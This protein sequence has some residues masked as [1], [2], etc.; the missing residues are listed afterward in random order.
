MPAEHPVEEDYPY[1]FGAGLWLNLK[2]LAFGTMNEGDTKT[3]K[4]KYANDTEH[5]MKLTFVVIGG[6]TDIKFTSPRMV[7]AKGRGEMVVTY[8]CSGN[9]LEM[10]KAHI[11][12]VINNKVSAQPL[13]VT[14]VKK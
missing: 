11:Y 13:T 9:F 12:P 6:N 4:L 2:V 5:E 1:Y 7:K 10:K 3:I 8:Q 14:W